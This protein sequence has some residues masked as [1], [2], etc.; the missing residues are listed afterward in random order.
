M[1]QVS[2]Y[3]IAKGVQIGTSLLESNLP[4]FAIEISIPWL[5]NSILGTF[6]LRLYSEL[7]PRYMYNDIPWSFASDNE[8]LGATM[9][10]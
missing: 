3:N 10:N 8:N 9:P 2:S 1:K 7:Q 4:K 5:S 6:A